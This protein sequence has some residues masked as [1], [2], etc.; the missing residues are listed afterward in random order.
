MKSKIEG[1]D[2]LYGLKK[3]LIARAKEQC[4]AVTKLAADEFTKCAK[5]SIEQFYKDYS[6]IYYDRTF[7]MLNNSYHR[8]Y[9]NKGNKFMGGVSVDPSL[10]SEYTHTHLSKDQ[11]WEMVWLYGYHGYENGD[12]QQG[13]YTTPPAELLDNYI[14][15]VLLNS[16]YA[17]ADEIAR[18]KVPL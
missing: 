11:I 13:I 17:R 1:L 14:N 4:M 18:K 12:S 3:K 15:D 6:P 9:S 8:I 5:F 10:L 7:D 2:N 16:I